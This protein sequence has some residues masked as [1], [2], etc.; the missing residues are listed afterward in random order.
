MDFGASSV[1]PS[2]QT[3]HAI[4]K[5]RNYEQT[6]RFDTKKLGGI[7]THKYRAF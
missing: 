7:I 1:V 5:I 2:V 6:K 4:H 3:D